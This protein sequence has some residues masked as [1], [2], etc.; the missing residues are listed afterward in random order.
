M[1]PQSAPASLRQRTQ[2]GQSTSTLMWLDHLPSSNFYPLHSRLVLLHLC[3]RA[4]LILRRLFLTTAT[5]T[6]VFAGTQA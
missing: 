1:G 5:S 2:T 6:T 4:T 3:S